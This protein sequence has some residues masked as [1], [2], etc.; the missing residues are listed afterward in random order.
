MEMPTGTNKA[1]NFKITPRLRW[2]YWTVTTVL[3]CVETGAGLTANVGRRNAPAP[4]RLLFP[5]RKP[6]KFTRK[7]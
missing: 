6:L 7:S 3:I 4:A 2:L 5:V 1:G